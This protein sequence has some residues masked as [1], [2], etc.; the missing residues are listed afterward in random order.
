MKRMVIIETFKAG[1]TS[2]KAE[3]EDAAEL[4]DRLAKIEAALGIDK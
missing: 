2:L 4:K 3:L 1:N